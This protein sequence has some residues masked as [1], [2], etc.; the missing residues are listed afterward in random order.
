MALR[1]YTILLNLSSGSSHFH[2]LY[3]HDSRACI[4][5]AT[6]KFETI[7]KKK[8]NRNFQKESCHNTPATSN[9]D[10]KYSKSPD[11]NFIFIYDK[12]TYRKLKIKMNKKL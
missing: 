1:F 11:I 9:K 7:K 8:K 3:P 5:I 6:L 2:K 4:A 12:N 10:L